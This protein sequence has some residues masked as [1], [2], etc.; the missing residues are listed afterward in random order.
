MYTVSLGL[1]STRSLMTTGPVLS[2]NKYYIYVYIYVY[3]LM[4]NK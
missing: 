2:L 1:E 3:Y 4:I